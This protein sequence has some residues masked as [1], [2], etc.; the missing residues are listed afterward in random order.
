MT[1]VEQ[2]ASFMEIV[3]A[4]SQVALQ[5]EDQRRIDFADYIANVLAATAANL[6]G[7]EELI[8]GRPGSWEA[9]YV[10]ALIQG[11]MGDHPRGWLRFRTEPVRVPMNLAELIENGDCHPGLLGI[12]DALAAIDERYPS[13]DDDGL[14][15]Y[16]AEVDAT[17]ARYASE[18][19]RYGARFTDAVADAAKKSELP[20]QVITDV[21]EDVRSHWWADSAIRNPLP[22]QDEIVLELWTDAHDVVPLPNVDV[23]VRRP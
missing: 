19:H 20:V 18:Y 11:T 22:C 4:L 15:A 13:T 8:A 5:R 10:F 12:D 23:R 14:D 2:S 16:E 17:T 21:D 7:P 3:R 1:S 6:G 9:S